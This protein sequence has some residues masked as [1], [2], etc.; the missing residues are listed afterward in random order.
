MNEKHVADSTVE[1]SIENI[2][3]YNDMNDYAVLEVLDDKNNLVTAVGTIPMPSEGEK[4]TLHG[5]W[6]YHTEYGKQLVVLSFEK[7]LPEA[8][9]DILKYLSSRTVKGVGPVTALKIVNRFGIDTFEVME[10][11]PEWLTDVSGITPKKAAAISKAF[12]EQTGLRSLM[13][14]CGD[15]L[16]T[17]EVTRVYKQL[18]GDSVEKITDNPYILCDEAC[19]IPFEKADAIAG[20][21]G[22]PPDHPERVSH[23]FRYILNYNARTNGH[24]CLPREKLIAAATETLGLPK[25]TLETHLSRCLSEGRLARFCAGEREMIMT[26]EIDGAES[27]I[28]KKLIALDRDCPKYS[29]ADIAL[30]VEKAEARIGIEYAALQRE[31]LYEALHR[32]V[33]ILTGGPGTGKTT[34]IRAMLFVFDSLGMKTVLA[35]PTGRAAKRMSEATSEEAKTVHRMLGMERGAE[36]SVRFDRTDRNPLEENVIIVDEASMIDL[37]LLEA[38]LHAIRRGSRLILIGDADQLPSVGAGNVLAD[39]IASGAVR[40]VSLTEV[41]RQSAESLIVTNAHR[42]RRGEMPVLSRADADF[43]FLRREEE[44]TIADPVAGLITERLPRA[45]GKEIREK[46]Q[47]IS[48]SK[49]GS[50]GVEILNARLQ[51]KLNPPAPF[52]KE[53]QS[54]GIT[55]RI[56]DRVMQNTNDYDIEWEKNGAV[57][58]GIFNGDIGVIEEILPSEEKMRIRFDE[59]LAEYPYDLLDELDLAYAITVH[60]SQGSEYPVVI[61]P[62]YSCAPILLT[63]NLFYTAIT[64]AKRMVILVGRADIVRTMVENHREILRYTTL[65]ERFSEETR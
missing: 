51:E 40:T 15:R 37:S 41:F 23:G 32:G 18:G 58:M 31:A 14:F 2:V 6:T 44:R 55:F 42:I 5:Y 60:K 21:L 3:Y 63:R 52:K 24:T 16:A 43:F 20:S 35:A 38:L 29:A 49:K 36:G 22:I 46:I 33:M 54:H 59:R 11:H 25:D 64:R 4:I 8:V 53:K 13:M 62:T 12:R 9:D 39:L 30:L 28:A 34:V 56:G 1:G 26:E 17:T 45:Y 57:G 47:V 7:R 50:G 27:Y 48:P 61:L 65:R 10:N 19:G